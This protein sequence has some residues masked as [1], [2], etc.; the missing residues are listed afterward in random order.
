MTPEDFVRLANAF[1]EACLLVRGT[2]EVVAANRAAASAFGRRP[3]ELVGERLHALAAD[4]PDRIDACLAAFARSGS[5]VPTVLTLRNGGGVAQRYRCEGAVTS[6]GPSRAGTL[7]VVRLR[8]QTV[9]SGHF[10]LL[11]QRIDALSRE[12]RERRRAETALEEQTAQLQEFATELE[13][14]IDELVLQKEEAQAARRMAEEASRA[15]S[16]FLATM[17]HE[18]RTPL[19][20]IVGYADLLDAGVG[21]PLSEVQ[22][23]HLARLR[24]SADHL[25]QLI[26]EVLT[27]SRLEAGREPVRVEGV[28]LAEVARAAAELVEPAAAERGLRLRVHVPR[29]PVPGWT[30]PAK[31]RQ[32][33]LNLLSNAVKFTERGEVLLALRVEA[34]WVQIAVAD[35][36]IGI[37]PEDQGRIFEPFTQVDGS[38]T[39]RAGGTGLGLSVSRGLAVLLGG[40]L[41]VS[42]VPGEGSTFT[43]H[44]P[45]AAPGIQR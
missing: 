32:I 14:T 27:F 22:H 36:G 45:G 37:L 17:S 9:A 41:T 30:D 12:V 18:L 20:A 3:H 19:N 2:G 26:D 13:Q 43:L 7:L 11:N 40:E 28:D 1:P 42:S 15:K 6:P 23:V 10:L 33:L 44:L 39:R 4:P 34:S 25:L 29:G 31:V 21:G 5:M 38:R 24:R 35:T 8:S 16:E